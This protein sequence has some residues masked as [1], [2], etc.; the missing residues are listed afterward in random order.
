MKPLENY[1]VLKPVAD[2]FHLD[3]VIVDRDD[4]GIVV[5]VNSLET[6]LK[7][8]DTVIYLTPKRVKVS[9]N[10]QKRYLVERANVMAVL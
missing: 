3:D 7:V 8:G 5:D 1:V 6:V 10:N 9:V 4:V 2:E